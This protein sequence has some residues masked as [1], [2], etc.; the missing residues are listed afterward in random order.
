MLKPGGFLQW[1]PG[2]PADR[3]VLFTERIETLRF[4][5]Q[6]LARDLKLQSGQIAVVHGSGIEDVDLQK[7]VEDFGRDRSP[8]RLLLASDIASEGLN[9]HFLCHKLIHFDIPWSLMVFQ[10][11]NGR[12][13]RYGQERQPHIAYLYTE[14]AAPQ[15]SRRLAHP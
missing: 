15:S 13:D 14:S 11:R 8:V 10:Q 12:I 6:N 5:E 7:M 2:N 9:L 4:L 3:V 1:D